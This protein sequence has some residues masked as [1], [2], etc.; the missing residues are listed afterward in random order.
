[1]I[2]NLAE[3]KAFYMEQHFFINIAYMKII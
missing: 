2:K 3:G 1:M